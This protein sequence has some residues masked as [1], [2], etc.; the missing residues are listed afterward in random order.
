MERE[1]IVQVHE[2]Y[3]SF[4]RLCTREREQPKRGRD[5]L[6]LLSSPP[7]LRHTAPWP[8][9]TM[10][11]RQP[12]SAV[13]FKPLKAETPLAQLSTHYLLP[14]AIVLHSRSDNMGA[15][16]NLNPA[17]HTP[18][19]KE[20]PGVPKIK[21]PP[22]LQSALAAI[23]S[24]SVD[25]LPHS[26]PPFPASNLFLSYPFRSCSNHF[27]QRLEWYICLKSDHF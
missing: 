7:S 11:W 8:R 6:L 15:C 4:T 3:F 19:S 16:T 24:Q 2:A 12:V 27:P 9:H 23:S 22:S 26:L 10:Q 25:Y 1:D 21:P 14:F 13:I 20:S 18:F 17:L 5:G